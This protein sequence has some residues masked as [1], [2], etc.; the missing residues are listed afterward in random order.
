MT[1]V[2][3]TKDE[4]AAGS[5]TMTHPPLHELSPLGKRHSSLWLQ[6]WYF[7]ILHFS[8]TLNTQLPYLQRPFIKVSLKITSSVK[9]NRLKTKFIHTPHTCKVIYCL[10]SLFFFSF[11]SLFIIQSQILPVTKYAVLIPF[12]LYLDLYYFSFLIFKSCQVP[13]MYLST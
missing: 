2:L 11:V 10:M 8:Q 6:L 5:P 9:F 1:T 4:D 7:P 13:K 12:A 3:S